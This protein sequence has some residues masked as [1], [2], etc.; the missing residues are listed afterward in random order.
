MSIYNPGSPAPFNPT[1]AN[2]GAESVA[3]S[4]PG[5]LA[6]G[7]DPR[8]IWFDHSVGPARLTSQSFLP[9]YTTLLPQPTWLRPE[10]CPR[11]DQ[12]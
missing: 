11:G 12:I 4:W 6:P 7:T 8:H 10:E 5:L 9:G 2:G 1:H 3:H